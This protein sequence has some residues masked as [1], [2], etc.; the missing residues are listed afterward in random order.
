MK[1]K[2]IETFVLTDNL[3]KSFFFSQWEYKQ[4]KICLVKITTENGTIGWGEGYGPADVLAAGVNYLS[5][6]VIGENPLNSEII[7]Q[8]LYRRTL[9][10]A[11]SGI[12]MA[13]VSAIDVA[14]WDLKGKILNMPVYQLLGGKKR[15]EIYPYATGL[16]FRK[17]ED[18]SDAMAREALSYKELGYKAIKMKV[19][20]SFED[21]I[22][23]IEVVRKAIGNSVELFV[24]ANHAYNLREAVQ[25]AKEIEKF[26][27]GWFEEPLSPEFYEQYAELRQKTSIPIA[28]GECEYLRYGFH[29]LLKNKS[30]DIIQP[31]ICAAGGLTEVKRIAVLSSVYGVELIPHTWGT[32]VAIAAAMHFVAN[33]DAIPG[34]L[35]KPTF[36]LEHDRTANGIRDEVTKPDF[37]IENGIMTF[38]N[39]PGLGV[40]VNESAFEN[41]KVK[42]KNLITN[43]F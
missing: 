34:R 4:R 20:L 35:K 19:G 33:L 6:Y 27:I 8:I 5:Q 12:L 1:I 26:N 17:E 9:D 16:Y 22:K 31:D 3:E 11:R 14:V 29:R 42:T 13:A 24:D 37:K 38:T 2:K 23:N 40:E 32:N 18:L 41:Y 15:D 10:Y 39:S 43:E 30:A 36:T 25:L 28:A 21:D 7:W